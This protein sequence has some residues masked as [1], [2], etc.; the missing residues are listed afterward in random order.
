MIK[1]DKT[2]VVGTL[3]ASAVFV[4]CNSNTFKVSGK[5][6]GAKDKSVIVERPDYN[7]QW[8]AVDSTRT[9]SSGDFSINIAAPGAPEVYRLV[10]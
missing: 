2:V 5:I 8:I 4:G 7:G 9:S 1:F 3:L 6:E 10:P